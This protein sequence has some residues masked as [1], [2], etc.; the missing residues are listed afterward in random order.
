M[1]FH[2]VPGVAAAAPEKLP[3]TQ[4]LG[5]QARLWKQKLWVQAPQSVFGQAL[6]VI[7]MLPDFENCWSG[8]GRRLLDIGGRLTLNEL[9]WICGP[10]LGIFLKGTCSRSHLREEQRAS[11]KPGFTHGGREKR[12]SMLASVFGVQGFTQLERRAHVTPSV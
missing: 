6:K 1:V 11:N 8:D 3:A 2:A 10:V 7:R 5:P 12:G 9:Q 4:N